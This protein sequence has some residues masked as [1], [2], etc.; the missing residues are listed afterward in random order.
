MQ[1]VIK[2]MLQIPIY[3]HL[4]LRPLEIIRPPKIPALL[5]KPLM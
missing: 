3:T 2:I 5:Q 4:R 1:F